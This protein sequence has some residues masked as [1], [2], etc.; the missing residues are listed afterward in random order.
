MSDNTAV[1]ILAEAQQI[2]AGATG[3][4]VEHGTPERAFANIAAGWE[5]YLGTRRAGRDAPIS[6]VDA[7]QML[8]LLKVARATGGRPTRDHFVDQANYS[9]LAGELALARVEQKWHVRC[10][11]CTKFFLRPARLD[12]F[13]YHWTCP[14]CQALLGGADIGLAQRDGA[15]LS[16]ADAAFVSHTPSPLETQVNPVDRDTSPGV[17]EVG[18]PGGEKPLAPAPAPLRGAALRERVVLMT[19]AVRKSAGISAAR[20]IVARFAPRVSEIPDTLLE[21][22]YH[23]LAAEMRQHGLPIPGEES[24][25]IRDAD[26]PPVKDDGIC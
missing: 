2:S 23:A 7:C 21:P 16:P 26:Q 17:R 6:D 22:L 3:K 1:G 13:N 14:H 24:T 4:H 9:A 20:A 10:P 15:W 5:W 8:A 12:R 25:P 19:H 11:K 18:W